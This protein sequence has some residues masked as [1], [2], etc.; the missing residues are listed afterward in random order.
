MFILVLFLVICIN[1]FAFEPNFYNSEMTSLVWKL[2]HDVI[3]MHNLQIITDLYRFLVTKPQPCMT[4][5]HV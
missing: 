1:I 2:L 5:N 4:A 3:N